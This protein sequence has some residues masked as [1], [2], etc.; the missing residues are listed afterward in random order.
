MYK[1]VNKIL[2]YNYVKNNGIFVYQ[3]YRYCEKCFGKYL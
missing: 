3:D 2:D 1:L